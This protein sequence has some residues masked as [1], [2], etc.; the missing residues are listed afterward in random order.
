MC[1]EITTCISDSVTRDLKEHFEVIRNIFQYNN[2][3]E[4]I[5][6]HLRYMS[7]TNLSLILG[8]AQSYR[9]TEWNLSHLT[10]QIGWDKYW[11]LWNKEAIVLKT[12]FNCFQD[13]KPSEIV[14]FEQSLDVD[15]SHSTALYWYWRNVR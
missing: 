8:H 15:V 10:L 4:V 14:Y 7:V 6:L 9:S 12:N 5:M 2:S 3:I 1:S 11:Q 13:A